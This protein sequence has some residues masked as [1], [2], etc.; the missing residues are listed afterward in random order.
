[1]LVYPFDGVGTGVANLPNLAPRTYQ[2]LVEQVERLSHIPT[3]SLWYFMNSDDDV[4]PAP[5]PEPVSRYI[6]AYDEA[7]FK[8]ITKG[9]P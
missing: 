7:T 6:P 4:D 5:S 1:M 3:A 2:Y 8:P 9:N